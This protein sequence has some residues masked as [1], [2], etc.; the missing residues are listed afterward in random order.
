MEESKS[1]KKE[2]LYKKCVIFL[3]CIFKVIYK[4]LYV[5]IIN[6]RIYK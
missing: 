1:I 2:S 5:K 4:V 6:D 3:V